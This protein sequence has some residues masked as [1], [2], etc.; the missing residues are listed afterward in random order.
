MEK[1]ALRT[2]RRDKQMH[3]THSQYLAH[4]P[5]PLPSCVA[6]GI[7][8][9]LSQLQ[10]ASGSGKPKRTEVG[11]DKDST[12][13]MVCSDTL[14]TPLLTCSAWPTAA[15]SEGR[16]LAS[17]VSRLAKKLLPQQWHLMTLV[18]A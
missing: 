1:R 18:P 6:Q 13:L 14:P 7:A 10:G 11:E 4:G 15:S 5:L 2:E 12:G 3:Y 17:V 16:R 9:A 8:Q